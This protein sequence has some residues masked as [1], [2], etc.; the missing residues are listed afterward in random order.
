[1]S[2]GEDDAEDGVVDVVDGEEDGAVDLLDKCGDNGDE[3][4]MAGLVPMFDDEEED[5]VV[6]LLMVDETGGSILE[7]CGSSL[8]GLYGIL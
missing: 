2:T 1:M 3:E 7:S 5:G 6:D 4:N 8:G